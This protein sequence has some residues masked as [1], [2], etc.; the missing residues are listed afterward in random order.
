MHPI[1][2]QLQSIASFTAGDDTEIQEVLHPQNDGMDFGFSLAHAALQPGEASRP[3]ILHGRS[4]TYIIVEGQGTAFVSGETMEA[5][6]GSVIFIPPGAEQYIQN[7]GE[8]PLHFWCV[9]CPPWTA[10]TEEVD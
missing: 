9:V 10:E 8:E 4:E 2:K 1:H 5:R 7:T 6:P 3:H